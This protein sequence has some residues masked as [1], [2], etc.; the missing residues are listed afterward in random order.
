MDVF[1]AAKFM[2]NRGPEIEKILRKLKR[3]EGCEGGPEEHV[4]FL[5][6]WSGYSNRDQWHYITMPLDNKLT[7]SM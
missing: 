6:F 2:T 7:M 4:F 1:G 5:G 3:F